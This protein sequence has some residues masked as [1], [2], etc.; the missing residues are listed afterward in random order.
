MASAP[1]S[2]AD[3]TLTRHFPAFAFGLGVVCLLGMIP[4]TL[5][6]LAG[7]GSLAAAVPVLAVAMVATVLSLV[8]S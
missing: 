3:E 1:E 2:T 7:V 5:A 6:A 8:T 4:V